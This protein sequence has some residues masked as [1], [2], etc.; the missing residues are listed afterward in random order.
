VVTSVNDNETRNMGRTGAMAHDSRY[1]RAD[2]FM[3]VVLGY[4]ESWDAAAIVADKAQH[5]S[6]HPD[7]V[8]RLDSHGRFLSS[9]GP[10]T[11]PR[12]PQGHPVII[13]AGMSGRGRAFAARWGEVLFVVYHTLEAGQQRYAAMK[14]A[15]AAVGLHPD[16]MK[17]CTL[18]YPVAV[19][20]AR[21]IQAPHFVTTSAWLDRILVPGARHWML[22][23]YHAVASRAQAD[24]HP[25]DACGGQAFIRQETRV[26]RSIDV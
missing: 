22:P 23:T 7:K 14:A 17:I 16:G 11:V 3:Q 10:F 18:F 21:T 6:A 8:R 1:D 25:D 24:L 12:S 19:C 5:L 15:A 13:Q 20:I 9:H 4:W 2:E 26:N